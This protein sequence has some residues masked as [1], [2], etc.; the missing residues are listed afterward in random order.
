MSS[1]RD[2][3]ARGDVFPS[4]EELDPTGTEV[5]QAS[6]PPAGGFPSHPSPTPGPRP[7]PAPAPAPT[8]V[9][10]P[11]P[12]PRAS[13]AQSIVTRHLDG[14]VEVVTDLDGDGVADVVQIDVDGD[15]IPDITYVDSD[16]DG[17]LDTVL[18]DPNAVGTGVH[19]A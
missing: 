5:E 19:R 16:R 15:G 7:T 3:A 14:S 1:Y 17:R 18:G 2:P 11:G 6:A 12:P 10:A 9:P 4:E 13:G 8:P